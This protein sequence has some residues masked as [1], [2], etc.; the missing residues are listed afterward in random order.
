MRWGISAAVCYDGCDGDRPDLHWWEIRA[1]GGSSL[2][3][4]ALIAAATD[5]RTRKLQVAAIEYT[6]FPWIGAVNSLLDSLIDQREDDAPGQHRLLDYYRAPQEISDRLVLLTE[7]A[8]IRAQRLGPGHGHALIVAAMTNFYLSS[9]DARAHDLRDIR[10]RLRIS[11]GHST[12]RQ[13]S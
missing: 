11:L 6:Y 1:A 7:Q 3:A 5:L 8:L 4:F 12:C 13:Y 2:A 9:L 10:K